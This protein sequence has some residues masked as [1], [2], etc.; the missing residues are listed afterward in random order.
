MMPSPGSLEIKKGSIILANIEVTCYIS[1]RETKCYSLVNQIL[2]LSQR[3]NF[4]YKLS[5]W[6]GNFCGLGYRI[7]SLNKQDAI[8]NYNVS[9][10]VFIK[11][12]SELDHTLHLYNKGA[13]ILQLSIN[14][15]STSKIRS[16]YILSISVLKTIDCSLIIIRQKHH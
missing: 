6:R 8:V 1:F 11:S 16:S 3:L 4:P 14:N 5:Y 7:V 10:N 12:R 9:V 2:R 13:Q 15:K